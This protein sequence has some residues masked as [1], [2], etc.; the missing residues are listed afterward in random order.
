MNRVELESTECAYVAQCGNSNSNSNN[1][2]QA[3]LHF[4]QLRANLRL[5]LRSNSTQHTKQKY[6]WE[7]VIFYCYRYCYCY[8]T[9]TSHPFTSH[10]ITHGSSCM[11]CNACLSGTHGAL[12]ANFSRFSTT[13]RLKHGFV[14]W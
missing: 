6:F 11:C 14:S 8:C 5:V 9:L 7:L 3:V 12:A 1:N 10:P 2:M 13:N 4:F